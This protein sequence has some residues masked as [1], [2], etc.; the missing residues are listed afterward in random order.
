MSF[1]FKPL[2]YD[3][4]NA[5]NVINLSQNTKDNAYVGTDVVCD[6]I[7]ESV[8]KNNSYKLAIDGYVS[9]TYTN[10]FFINALEAAAKK[11]GV[12]CNA[13]SMD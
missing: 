13:L 6:K 8:I 5:F 12:S 3:D 7:V 9:S 1:M 2:A 10:G 4:P 11:Q